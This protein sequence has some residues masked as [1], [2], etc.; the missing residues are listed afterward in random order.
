MQ[1]ASHYFDTFPINFRMKF[2]FAEEFFDNQLEK[3]YREEVST[4]K[5]QQE[6]MNY[7]WQ[8]QENHT[9]LY[10]DF[11]FRVTAYIEFLLY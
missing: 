11:Q 4:K 6:I 9:M 7:Y 3:S 10:I 1:I 8:I 5:C 2:A